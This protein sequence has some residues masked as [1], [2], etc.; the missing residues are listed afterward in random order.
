MHQG[1]KQLRHHL[2]PRRELTWPSISRRRTHIKDKAVRN[3]AAS[4]GQSSPAPE[5]FPGRNVP[6]SLFLR[7]LKQVARRFAVAD[8]ELP[9]TS[10]S[11]S[12]SVRV[13]WPGA[14]FWKNFCFLGGRWTRKRKEAFLFH[15][16]GAYALRRDH[17]GR[18]NPA[19]CAV[20]PPQ[21]SLPLQRSLRCHSN[22][23]CAAT[24]TRHALPLQP[25]TPPAF[26]ASR[27]PWRVGHELVLSLFL[28]TT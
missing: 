18:L 14:V 11:T 8:N 15:L 25:G 5:F 10:T 2:R 20:T 22:P 3:G 19:A 23:A 1:R 6:G 13:N 12:T 28:G 16:F 21:L 24:A 7:Q 4:R 9:I 27:Q 17:N 26:V